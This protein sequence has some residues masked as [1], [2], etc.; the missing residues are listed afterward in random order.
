MRG[1]GNGL[2]DCTEAERLRGSK[3][4][5]VNDALLILQVFVE[6]EQETGVLAMADGSGDGAFIVLPSFV[7]LDDSKNI[8]RVEYGIAKQEVQRAMI[9]G[10][11]ALSD[12][13]QT[14]AAG[15]R[16][17]GGVWVA[18]DLYF[19]NSGWSHAGSIR[20]NAVH[21]Q[22]NAVGSSGIVIKE[23]RHGRDVVLIEDRDAVEC[24]AI[25][26]VRVLVL[27]AL[28]A[29]ERCGISG[30]DRDAFVKN[31]DLHGDT[32]RSLTFRRQVYVDAGWAKTLSLEIQNVVATIE[33]VEAE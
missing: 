23:A 26:G 11:S 14:S 6:R 16:E 15:T 24:V 25:D 30:S 9:V 10:R 33:M 8:R 5:R 19:L 32:D 4:C 21:H 22:R 20:L 7:R 12:Y 13:F 31:R 2:W 3:R 18:V 29:D 28:D 1:I 27:G 17:A